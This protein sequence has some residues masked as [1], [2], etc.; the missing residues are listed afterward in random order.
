M[1]FVQSNRKFMEQHFKRNDKGF[2][3]CKKTNAPL[4][5]AELKVTI[6]HPD[7][8]PRVMAGTG[9]TKTIIH[10]ACTEC[11]P[12]AKPPNNGHQVYEDELVS[13]PQ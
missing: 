2:W 13:I 6:L 11:F 3:F 9:E 4:Q 1:I 12:N 7:F 5:V 8:S 10:I